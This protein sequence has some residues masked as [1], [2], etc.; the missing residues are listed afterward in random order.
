MLVQKGT[1]C[2]GNARL[3][4]G[5]WV[6]QASLPS[7]SGGKLYQDFRDGVGSGLGHASSG[8]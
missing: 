4:A 8:S 7:I 3:S 5:D 6:S 2:D 1:N